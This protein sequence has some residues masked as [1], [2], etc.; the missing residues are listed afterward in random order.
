[1]PRPKKYHSEEEALIAHKEAQ[2]RANRAAMDRLTPVEREYRKL[3]AKISSYGKFLRE[4]ETDG[5]S[6]SHSV[7]SRHRITFICADELALR[8]EECIRK[9]RDLK[10]QCQAAVRSR[11]A[12]RKRESKKDPTFHIT[13]SGRIASSSKELR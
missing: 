1:M 6:S 11:R 12:A 10:P 7:T 2:L 5:A 9:A 13:Q 3:M 4:R 8:I